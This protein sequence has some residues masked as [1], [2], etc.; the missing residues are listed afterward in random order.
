MGSV[1]CC[2]IQRFLCLGWSPVAFRRGSGYP[3]QTSQ[4]LKSR[5]SVC[6][7]KSFYDILQYKRFLFC[8]R[9]LYVAD[10]T[11]SDCGIIEK[12]AYKKIALQN[13]HKRHCLGL[14]ITLVLFRQKKYNTFGMYK[15]DY[16]TRKE[17]SEKWGLLPAG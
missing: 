16:M 13:N 4:Q 7:S 17:A 10:N 12:A 2:L 15:M 1:E 5:K 8:W 14:W 6:I 3:F 9:C 11:K